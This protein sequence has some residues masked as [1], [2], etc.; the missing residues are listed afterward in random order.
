MR[1]TLPFELRFRLMKWLETNFASFKSDKE[2]ADSAAAALG[3]PVTF[4]N[5]EICRRDLGIVKRKRKES[6]E[7][8]LSAKVEEL[9]ARLAVIESL[10]RVTVPSGFFSN[11]A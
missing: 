3:F 10:L 5:I 8:A 9:S 1:N 11:G 7:T 4:S 2:L 6:D